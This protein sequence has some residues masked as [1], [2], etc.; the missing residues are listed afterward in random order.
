MLPADFEEIFP[1]SQMEA[2]VCVRFSVA[3]MLNSNS[4]EQTFFGIV[5][6]LPAVVLQNVDQIT[7]QTR[8]NHPIGDD[9]GVELRMP[10]QE[11]WREIIQYLVEKGIC[12]RHKGNS[13]VGWI[14]QSSDQPRSSKTDRKKPSH[15]R[16]INHIKL[17]YHLGKLVKAK[18]YIAANFN[19]LPD[20]FTHNRI[21]DPSLW[22]MEGNT[23]SKNAA[24]NG[25]L[26]RMSSDNELR[27]N[28]LKLGEGNWRAVARLA[29]KAGFQFQEDEIVAVIPDKFYQ[30]AREHSLYGW[31]NSKPM[32]GHS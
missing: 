6:R 13:L 25:F 31:A 17:Q 30:L 8:L 9:Y 18:A 22:D 21:F 11:Y 26:Q 10:K 19:G 12:D 3:D 28:L 29:R 32:I 15:T 5:D 2:R 1:K 23:V 7:I 14:G 4:T 27:Q 20:Q 16:K 24:V